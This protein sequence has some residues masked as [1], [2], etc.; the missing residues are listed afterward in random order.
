MLVRLLRK[1]L[2]RGLT[3]LFALGLD[4]W[5]YKGYITGKEQEGWLGKIYI[6]GVN[7]G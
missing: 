2:D 4:I 1:F 5:R 3:S 7:I 6:P